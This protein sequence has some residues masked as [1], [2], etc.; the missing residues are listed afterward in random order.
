MAG[1]SINS[2]KSRIKSVSGTRQITRAMELVS[3]SK[4]RRAK[5]RAERSRPFHEA[6]TDTIADLTAAGGTCAGESEFLRS[7]EVKKTCFVVI[8]GDRG[9]AGAYNSNL[10][11]HTEALSQGGAYCVLPV[12][13]KA[14]EYYHRR[15]VER[16]DIDCPTLA[17]AD[18]GVCGSIASI[19][20]DAYKEGRIDRVV[21]VYT[22]FVSM[23]S[24]EATDEVVLPIAV[25]EKEKS[26]QREFTIDSDPVALIDAMVPF[27]VSGLLSSAV[28]E[29]TASEHGARR[30]AMSSASKNAGELID[31]LQ[32]RFNR[33]RQAAIT[34]EISEIVSGADAL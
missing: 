34:Q 28:A 25:P 10:F 6:L 31:T 22:R 29:A 2:I 26:A 12:G 20:C 27:C 30:N 1:M 19:L 5:E 13:K 32:L 11:R 3:S 16:I 18:V 33:A 9:L 24:Q 23:L 17:D 21:V 8:A 14:K 7:R 15:G 4:L